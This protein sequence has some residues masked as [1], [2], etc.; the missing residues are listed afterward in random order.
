MAGMKNHALV[1]VLA[2]LTPIQAAEISQDIM[3]AK[4]KHAPEGRGTIAIGKHENIGT[5]LQRGQRKAI[6]RKE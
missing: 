6:G 5:L 3:K 1:A 4:Q 2:G